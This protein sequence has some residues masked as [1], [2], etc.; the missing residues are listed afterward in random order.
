VKEMSMRIL[1]L[2][3]KPP[4]PAIDGGC[5]A[6]N[7]ITQGLLKAGHEVKVLTIET[8][9]HPFRPKELSE[10][11]L[12]NTAIE[13]VYVDT[14]L[15]L[16]DAFSS[17]VTADS[18]NISRFFSPDFDI[19]LIQTLRQRR[20]DVIH[21]ESLFM[22]PYVATIRRYTKAK[23]VV[24][25]HNLEYRIWER[26]AKGSKNTAKRMY[27]NHLAKQLK[28]YE[29]QIFDMIDGIAAITPEDALK[30]AT[31]GCKK[32][33]ITIPFGIDVDEYSVDRSAMEHPSLFHLGSMDWMPNKEGV[34]WFLEN[35]WPSI[36][37]QQPNLKL[38]LAGRNMNDEM[39]AMDRPNVVVLGEVDDATKF[40]NSKSVMLVPLLSAGGMRVKIIE[41]MAL[42]KAIIS[43]KIG[44]EGVDYTN[45][46]HIL[47]ANNA[48]E[49]AF[50]INKV[51]NDHGLVNTIGQNARRLI[52][53]DYDNKVITKKLT[54]FY[55]QLPSN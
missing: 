37:E 26:M 16:V 28:K 51:V 54:E 32:P 38:Y 3:N 4:L 5:I 21:L 50:M 8:D 44:A 36:H 9:K 25:S 18:Y 30:Y 17:L 35:V 2:C 31:L 33:I 1:Q 49:F 39:L 14:K 43:T 41:G 42:G 7:N 53:A 13:A 48:D 22:T 29:L 52:E 24:R 34:N 20:F 45:M 46:E 23:V 55:S 12:F 11:Y 40:M 10:S 6:M 27:I 19:K 15:N 47:I